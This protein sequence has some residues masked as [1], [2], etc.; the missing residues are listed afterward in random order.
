MGNLQ[1]DIFPPMYTPVILSVPIENDHFNGLLGPNPYIKLF[2][3]YTDVV[4]QFTFSLLVSQDV[5]CG[6]PRPYSVSVDAIHVSA[7]KETTDAVNGTRN[8]GSGTNGFR[9]GANEN[10]MISSS[11]SGAGDNVQRYGCTKQIGVRSGGTEAGGGSGGTGDGSGVCG[12]GGCG[13]G[14]SAGG[15]MGRGYGSNVCSGGCVVS[16]NAP[17][18]VSRSATFVKPTNR[19][20][21]A[22]NQHIRGSN[23]ERGRARLRNSISMTSTQFHNLSSNSN[24]ANNRNM[25]KGPPSRGNPTRSNHA[26]ERNTARDGN[27]GEYIVSATRTPRYTPTSGATGFPTFSR[28]NT[29]S[30]RILSTSPVRRCVDARQPVDSTS[31]I[32][33]TN[34]AAISSR[35]SIGGSAASRQRCGVVAK[36]SNAAYTPGDEF[37]GGDVGED[38]DVRGQA[39]TL[40]SKSGSP[41][42]NIERA[43]S[44]RNVENASLYGSTESGISS[45]GSDAHVDDRRR[46]YN[47]AEG[48]YLP[49]DSLVPPTPKKATTKK[50]NTKK[51]TAFVI[52]FNDSGIESAS[53]GADDDDSSSSGDQ[54]DSTIPPENATYRADEPSGSVERS[55]GDRKCAATDRFSDNRRE[56]NHYQNIKPPMSSIPPGVG[57]LTPI[58]SS[59]KEPTPSHGR[60]TPLRVKTF[61]G[62]FGTQPYGP[63]G[64]TSRSSYLGDPFAG[65]SPVS[66]V[67]SSYQAYQQSRQV[68]KLAPDTRRS[69]G[70]N[71][72]SQILAH[73]TQGRRAGS[74]LSDV[75]AYLR[76]S[77]RYR[78][79]SSEGRRLD[80]D[81]MKQVRITAV[82]LLM[83]KRQ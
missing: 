14:C 33:F 17:S 1:A 10:G 72:R 27:I 78:P 47:K 79:S 54:L 70:A 43:R 37:G 52:T 3:L 44:G 25:G 41:A 69:V 46:T 67:R 32:G 38:L 55:S 59:H 42:G 82:A 26:N 18:P 83:F 75:S 50:K 39:A 77:S 45:T 65:S 63:E 19:S 31:G 64:R 29:G 35:S 24:K 61:E 28:Y 56:P 30:D 11:G 80:T 2:A 48:F 13:G 68:P 60:R 66:K 36:G 8:G 4:Y 81:A 20:D 6:S 51:G 12:G 74:P 40:Y 5:A 22:N 34:R 9:C 7:E 71:G 16:T 23:P 21:T 49:L 62:D 73:Q 15:R 57:I 76:R 58:R 53:L